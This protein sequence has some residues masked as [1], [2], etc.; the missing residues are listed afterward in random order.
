MAEH[1]LRARGLGPPL[2][3]QQAASEAPRQLRAAPRRS[4]RQVA[5]ARSDMHGATGALVYSPQR[6]AHGAALTEEEGLSEARG[7]FAAEG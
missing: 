6:L 1:L 5:A 2:L 4:A 7:S 3:Q